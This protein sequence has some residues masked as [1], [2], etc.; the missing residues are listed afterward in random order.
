MLPA[1]TINPN[2]PMNITKQ[3]TSFLIACTLALGA[4]PAFAGT[5]S[6]KHFKM[7][8]TDG[9]GKVSRAEHT[10]FAKQMFAKCDANRDGV[11]TAAEMDAANA[12]RDEKPAKDEMSS[13]EKI[14]EIDQNHDGKLTTAEHATG[15]ETMFGK[16]DTDGDGFLSKDECAAAMKLMKKKNA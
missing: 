2:P 4:L 16:M 3:R 15:T 1:L 14:R 10:T 6:D 12:A 5:D 11:V 8:D 7:M 13:A 9:D